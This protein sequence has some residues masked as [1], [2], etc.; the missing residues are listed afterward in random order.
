MTTVALAHAERLPTLDAVA[1]EKCALLRALPADG[2]AI[3]SLDSELLN[4]RRG[5]FSA[6]RVLSFGAGDGAD[7]QLMARKLGPDMVTHCA[8]GGAAGASLGFDLR[9]FGLGPALDAA[10]RW[11]GACTARCARAAAR[12]WQRSPTGP[13]AGRMR[14]CRARRSLLIDDSYNANPASMLSSL[15]ALRELDHVLRQGRAIAALGDMAELGEHA[16]PSTRGSVA[17]WCARCVS[18][19]LLCG[20]LMAHAARAAREEVTRLRARARTSARSDPESGVPG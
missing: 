12:S 2:A 5:S 20:P 1:D 8:L 13:L 3:Y 9:L 11:R 17:S 4:A 15:A 16:Q 6:E 10:R 19:A 18:E 14:P 7:L